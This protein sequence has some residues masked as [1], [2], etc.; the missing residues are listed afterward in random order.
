[1]TDQLPHNEGWYQEQ[2]L[3]L[4]GYK[5]TKFCISDQDSHHRQ[6]RLGI[7]VFLIIK[8]SVVRSVCASFLH[9]LTFFKTHLLTEAAGDVNLGTGQ[10][11][12]CHNC[13][14]A[15]IK[16]QKKWQNMVQHNIV[17]KHHWDLRASDLLPSLFELW[18]FLGGGVNVLR[19]FGGLF[20][21]FGD[22][23][24]FLSVSGLWR[25]VYCLLWW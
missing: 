19:F 5:L 13:L 15:S 4:S 1:M 6:G 24:A 2:K 8:T 18:S 23:R 20:F 22:E 3:C 17:Q 16:N 12:A 25:Q 10:S 9:N 7:V 14:N 21:F 11:C